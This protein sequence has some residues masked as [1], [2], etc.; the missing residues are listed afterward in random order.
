MKNECMGLINLDSIQNPSVNVLSDHRP[1]ATIPIAGRYRL[2]DFTLSNMVNSGITNVGIYAREKY[3]SLTDHLGSG[4]DW[5]LSRKQGGLYV[6]SPEN[7]K[8][9][10]NYGYRKGDI[11]TILANID[12]IEKSPEEYVIVAPSYMI[13]SIDYNDLLKYH[14]KSNSPKFDEFSADYTNS[15]LV[16]VTSEVRD[17]EDYMEAYIENRSTLEALLSKMQI[18][19]ECL[20][21]SCGTCNICKRCALLD[22]KNCYHP[23]EMRYSMEAMGMDLA[24][25]SEEIFDH[26]LTWNSENKKS[27][28]CTSIGSILFN[29]TFLED[30]FCDLARNYRF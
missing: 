16:E 11:Y 21:T 3:R 29:G 2:I 7:A 22:N 25:L 17:K 10:N 26:K 9:N 24:K 1:V 14:K 4:K 15:L 19:F 20:K 13:C 23:E 18:D 6:L 28:I 12:Y 8:N 5:D 27:N 30:D